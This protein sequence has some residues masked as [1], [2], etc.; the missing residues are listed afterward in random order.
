MKERLKMIIAKNILVL[1]PHPDDGEFGCGASIAKFKRDGAKVTYAVFSLCEE[2]LPKGCD[3]NQL[4]EELFRATKELGIDKKDLI[5]F[6]FKVRFFPRDRQDILEKMVELN[7]KL[8]P[9][10]VFMPSLND[11]HQDH[12]TLAEEGF[13]AF[14]KSSILGYEAPW[15]NRAFPTTCFIEISEQD[16]MTKIKAIKCY[17]SQ[18]SKIYASESFIKSMAVI[19]GIQIGKEFSETFEVIRIVV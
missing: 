19:R 9:D 2:S 5:S 11:T 7:K 18:R 16:L 15:N 6:D 8:K 3:I 1:S 14:K 10:L 4:K 12:L 17:E 13:R